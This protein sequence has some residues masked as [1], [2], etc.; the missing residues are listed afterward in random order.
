VLSRK[1][2]RPETKLQWVV[3]NL[4]ISG[5]EAVAEPNLFLEV[6]ISYRIRSMSAIS[7]VYRFGD[8]CEWYMCCVCGYT[9][10]SQK[11]YF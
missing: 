4:R 10:S 1:A 3:E 9:S 8:P 5:R 2:D 6:S 7:V 11:T